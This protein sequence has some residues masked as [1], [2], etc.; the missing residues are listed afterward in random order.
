MWSF[1]SAT[2]RSARSRDIPFRITMRSAARSWRFSGKVYAG[3]SQPFVAQ[4]LGN[5]EHG[6]G[7]AGILE[8]EREHRQLAA[9][10]D[11]LERPQLGN[12]IGCVPGDVPARLLHLPVAVEAEP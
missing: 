6:V 5:I 12:R 8:S 9:V 2:R 1:K 4:T 3:T 7:T 10:G 11:E